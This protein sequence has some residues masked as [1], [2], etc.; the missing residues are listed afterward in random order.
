VRESCPVSSDVITTLHNAD[1]D[2]CVKI[3]KR[4]DGGFGLREFRRDPEDAGAWT[5]V[6]GVRGAT[7]ATAEQA[8][9]AAHAGVDWLGGVAPPGKG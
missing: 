4:P 7:Y 5:L 9:A 6:G 3:V 2:R 8:A 1:G